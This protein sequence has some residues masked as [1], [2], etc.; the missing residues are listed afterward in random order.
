MLENG[1]I[2]DGKYK[3]LDKIGQGG[4]SVVYL[5]MNEKVNKQWAIKEVRKD[6]T[7]NFEVVRQGLITE[8]NLL[9]KLKHPNLP[10][11]IDI[12]DTDETF[13]IVM[14]FIEGVTLSVYLEDNGP[15]P[16]EK[17]I[18][19]ASQLCDV[20]SYLHSRENPIIFRD[21]KSGNVML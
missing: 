8:T 17:V 13:L 11:I 21:I 5:A 4:M 18:G 12:I 9:K 1:T 2:V 14:D 7:D 16:Q 3:I 15:Q 6:V 20:L 19:W 10:S